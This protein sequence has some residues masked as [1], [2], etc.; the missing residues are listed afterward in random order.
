[1]GRSLQTL[2]GPR[3]F[4]PAIGGRRLPPCAHPE[5]LLEPLLDGSQRQNV[6][7]LRLKVEEVDGVAGL[8]AIEDA[9]LDHVQLEAAGE[10]VEHGGPDAAARADSPDQQRVDPLAVE[11]LL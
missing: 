3:L 8:A 9:I 6:G 11:P 2:K 4:A 5:V 1:M 10:G 7:V